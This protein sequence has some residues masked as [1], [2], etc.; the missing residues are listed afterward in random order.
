MIFVSLLTPPQKLCQRK[1]RA[2]MSLSTFLL[3]LHM[4]AC[5]ID[6]IVGSKTSLASGNTGYYFQHCPFFF[7]SETS[8][9]V[10]AGFQSPHDGPLHGET[11]IHL[12]PGTE[13]AAVRPAVAARALCGLCTGGVI[14]VCLRLTIVPLSRLGCLDGPVPLS[15]WRHCSLRPHDGFHSPARLN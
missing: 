10:I 15:W 1:F 8:W 5:F 2:V 4:T 7:F 6:F 9:P 11:T 13:T 14:A 3:K 12:C